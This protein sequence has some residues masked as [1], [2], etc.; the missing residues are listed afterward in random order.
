MSVVPEI[1]PAAFADAHA[2]GAFVVDVR[3][4]AEYVEGH[5][6]GAQLLPLPRIHGRLGELPN[7]RAVYVICATGNR[8]KTAASWMRRAGIDAISVAGGTGGWI[9]LGKPVIRGRLADE[10]AA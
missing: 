4:P 3:A 9:R 5:V 10:P 2:D 8:S 6:P 7:D 1:Q